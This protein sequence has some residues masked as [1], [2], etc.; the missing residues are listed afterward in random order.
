MNEHASQH[1]SILPERNR[2]ESDRR[3]I[4]ESIRQFEGQIAASEARAQSLGN[5]ISGDRQRHEALAHD[6]MTA[7]QARETSQIEFDELQ[8]NIQELEETRNQ[9]D[10]KAKDCAREIIERRR[11]RDAMNNELN[12]LQRSL[13]QRKS[14]LEI[15]E[16]LLQKG[17]GLS[18]GTQKVISGLDNPE[19]YSVGVR[20]LLAS[21][22]EV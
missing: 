15:I 21:S 10:E 18:A 7:Q 9:L 3:A 17:E 19:V 16:Q 12:D 4:R 22:I 13:T 6:R 11:Q 2:L 14:R 1:Q 20:G 5:Q 8:R